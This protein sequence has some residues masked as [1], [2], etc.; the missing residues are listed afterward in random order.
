MF[1]VQKE[2]NTPAFW[3][4]LRQR[5]AVN[6]GAHLTVHCKV[7]I[8]HLTHLNLRLNTLLYRLGSNPL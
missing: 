6:T 4:A 5:K 7:D 2:L 1:A 3:A 8:C